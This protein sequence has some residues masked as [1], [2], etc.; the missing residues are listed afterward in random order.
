MRIKV[1][2]K[3]AF[4]LAVLLAGAC[5]NKNPDSLVGKNVDENLAIMDANEAMNAEVPAADDGSSASSNESAAPSAQQADVATKA[6]TDS[7]NSTAADRRATQ[8]DADSYDAP[9]EDQG[10]TV[11][12]GSEEAP[13]AV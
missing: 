4:A 13:N 6:K 5:S 7:Q 12:P 11:E 10:N 8:V 9:E 3:A 1:R 2:S